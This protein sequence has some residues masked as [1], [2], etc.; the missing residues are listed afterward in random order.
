[1]LGIDNINDIIV[2]GVSALAS[3]VTIYAKY[4]YDKRKKQAKDPV[5]DSVETDRAVIDKLHNV[6]SELEADRI[7]IIEFHNG[8]KFYNGRSMQKFSMTYELCMPGVSHE[9]QSLQNILLSTYSDLIMTL[10]INNGKSSINDVNNM[11]EGPLKQMYVR[12]GTISVYAQAIKSLDNK[13][14]GVILVDYVKH[15]KTLNDGQLLVL[16]RLADVI[17]GYL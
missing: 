3:L 9:Q 7:S 5:L 13:I 15:A 10:V 4:W 16:E 14:T 6:M 17:G 12:T 8:G 11:P 2:S 1:M